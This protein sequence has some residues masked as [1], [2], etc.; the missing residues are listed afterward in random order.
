VIRAAQL[1]MPV[2][3]TLRPAED[4]VLSL[5]LREPYVTIA[6]GL[7]R[8]LPEAGQSQLAIPHS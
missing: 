6:Q 4:T 5:V 8:R 1:G 2:P 7:G 3:L